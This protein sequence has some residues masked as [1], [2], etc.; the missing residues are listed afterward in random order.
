MMNCFMVHWFVMNWGVM[1][2]LMVRW[3]MM[4]NCWLWMCFSFRF[5]LFRFLFFC[6]FC[7]FRFNLFWLVVT[8]LIP[9]SKMFIIWVVIVPIVIM[10]SITLFVRWIIMEYREVRLRLLKIENRINYNVMRSFFVM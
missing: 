3:S 5:I 2:R 9:G 6:F 7:F 10:L 8:L 1:H 4:D